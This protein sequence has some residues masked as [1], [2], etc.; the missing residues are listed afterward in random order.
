M[1]S[2]T[3]QPVLKEPRLVGSLRHEIDIGI[4][5][6]IGISIPIDLSS[7]ICM[8]KK[9]PANAAPGRGSNSGAL[10][11][12]HSVRE[13]TEGQFDYWISCLNRAVELR[14]GDPDTFTPDDRQMTISYWYILMYL[15]ELYAAE[16]NPF[17]VDDV[18]KLAD[19]LTGALV[20]MH[21]LSRDLRPR[22]KGETV[23]RYIADLRGF[24]LIIQD[25][26]GPS[27]TIQLTEPAIRALVYTMRHWVVEFGKLNPLLQDFFRA[28]K[29]AADTAAW[30]KAS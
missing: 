5:I 3:L 17:D 15:L 21:K 12:V 13:L 26:R 1:G 7:E 29:A 19:G 20:S 22:Y 14:G 16:R 18:E 11:L 27:A 30:L 8:T 24:R 9:R 2:S 4:A 28:S 25:G 6:P 23:R 10:K